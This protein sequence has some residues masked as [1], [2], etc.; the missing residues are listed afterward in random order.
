MYRKQTA[1]F[2]SKEYEWEGI[3]SDWINVANQSFIEFVTS[4]NN[5][6]GRLQHAIL[7]GSSVIY[8]RCYYW[9]HY[10]AI[11]APA[12]E[13]VMMFSISKISGHASSRFGWVLLKDEKVYQKVSH[14]MTLSTMG[15]SRDTQLRILKI[16]KAILPEIKGEED[17]FEYGHKMM[18][19]R[20]ARL[21][22]LVS[23]SKRFSLQQLAPQNCTYS[24][25]NRDPSPGKFYFDLKA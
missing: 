20:W 19:E 1:L 4:P 7:K 10:T 23:S 9:P 11:P 16:I 3:T 12:D 15:V 6:D 13:D 2:D 5:P 8:D 24:Q 25:K 18:S 22:K 17:I 21:N 14:Y